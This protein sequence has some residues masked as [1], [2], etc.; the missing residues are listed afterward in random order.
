MQIDS[1]TDAAGLLD[2]LV[3]AELPEG[4]GL[5]AW[6]ALLQAHATLMRRLESD[7]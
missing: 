3:V 1:G 7:L 2:G 5:A 6:V 4:R